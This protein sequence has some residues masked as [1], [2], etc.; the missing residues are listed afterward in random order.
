MTSWIPPAVLYLAIVGLVTVLAG[1]ALVLW[2]LAHVAVRV[3]RA[4]TNSR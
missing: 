2:G 1:L 4:V 3:W